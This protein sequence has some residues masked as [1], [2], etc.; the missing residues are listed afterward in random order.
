[1][2]NFHNCLEEKEIKLGETSKLVFQV[3]IVE[4]KE[5]LDV[6]KWIL[7]PNASDFVSSKKGLQLNFQK[8]TEAI[9]QIKSLIKEA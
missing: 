3:K 5:Q 1:M 4:G 8:W 6:R 2:N 9:E 7:Y